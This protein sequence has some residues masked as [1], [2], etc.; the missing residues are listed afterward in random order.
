MTKWRS[1]CTRSPFLRNSDTRFVQ[2]DA[3]RN[4]DSSEILHY[5]FFFETRPIFVTIPLLTTLSTHQN[6]I[7]L[8][9][10]F[11]RVEWFSLIMN[12]L[13][14][15]LSLWNLNVTLTH[16]QRTQTLVFGFLM[17]V[18]WSFFPS[19]SD[20]YRF[21]VSI[22]WFPRHVHSGHSLSPV[23]FVS[24]T[25][26]FSLFCVIFDIDSLF[27]PPILVLYTTYSTIILDDTWRTR[28]MTQPFVQTWRWQTRTRL[29][30]WS[31]TT[32]ITLLL[33]SPFIVSLCLLFFI[34]VRT[35]TITRHNNNTTYL[36]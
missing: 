12:A 17:I 15:R 5:L 31:P 25:G 6:P 4:E 21:K 35:I 20:N 32:I 19:L 16:G 36:N 34:L 33:L 3:K 29:D 14:G 24:L 22:F 2:D 1:E 13:C 27:S 8:Y 9:T 23:F 11:A 30:W 7:W 10:L 28:Q 26:Y 18:Q